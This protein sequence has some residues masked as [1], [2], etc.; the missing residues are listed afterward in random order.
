[1]EAMAWF[2]VDFFSWSMMDLSIVMLNYKRVQTRRKLQRQCEFTWKKSIYSPEKIRLR[3][4][5]GILPTEAPE[6]MVS[7]MDNEEC[8]RRRGGFSR[9]FLSGWL[10]GQF[11]IWDC[12]P[13]QTPFL[14]INS[15]RGKNDIEQVDTKV[16]LAVFP[17]TWFLWSF[18]Q[19]QM[20]IKNLWKFWVNWRALVGTWQLLVNL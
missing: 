7:F 19:T 5:R 6:Q 16:F 18:S 3:Q 4:P 10:L 9:G 11:S 14:A 13:G 12:P 17:E 1:M 15:T 8:W 2:I 20:G